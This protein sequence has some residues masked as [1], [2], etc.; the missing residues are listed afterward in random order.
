[1]LY[2]QKCESLLLRDKVEPLV[3]SLI[4]LNLLVISVV[5]LQNWLLNFTGPIPN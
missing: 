3:R 5:L 2:K 4:I 1:M